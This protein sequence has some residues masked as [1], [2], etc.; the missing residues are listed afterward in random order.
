MLSELLTEMLVEMLTE[1]LAE[2]P[3]EMLAGLVVAIDRH[4]I[5]DNMKMILGLV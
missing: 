1:V 3:V 2:M 4:L 5:I